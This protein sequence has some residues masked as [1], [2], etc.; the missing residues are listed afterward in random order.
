MT[1]KNGMNE[2]DNPRISCIIPIYNVE[3][4]LHRCIDSI[5]AQT[6]TDFE[7]I[8]VDDGS[9]DNCG[10][11]CDEYAEKNSR[12]R[13]IHQTNNGVSAAR[14]A[15][16]DVAHGEY[17]CFVDG[18]DYIAL[19][20]FEFFMNETEIKDI[21]MFESSG[22]ILNESESNLIPMR[23][24][25]RHDCIQH[26]GTWERKLLKN[27][28]SVHS[29]PRTIL[30]RRSIIESQKIR[31]NENFSFLEDVGFIFDLIPVLEKIKITVQKF[32]F[33]RQVE[34]SLTHKPPN[35]MKEKNLKFFDY[36]KEK[37]RYDKVLSNFCDAMYLYSLV[38]KYFDSLDEN[39]KKRIKV[40][41]LKIFTSMRFLGLRK[42]MVIAV[43]KVTP[44]TF[45]KKLKTILRGMK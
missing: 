2:N 31:Y 8:L 41:P 30:V 11:I 25:Y 23:L 12:V 43:L 3:K 22:F 21:D 36:A 34:N 35:E 38:S 44:I 17:V 16:L 4:Y 40:Y 26:I 45:D 5:L 39:I 15:G 42:S 9:P 24:C 7:L 18:D 29:M 32:Y 13:V 27:I 19:E 1:M 10:K 37:Y 28:F 20:T 14:N 33:Y 6:F